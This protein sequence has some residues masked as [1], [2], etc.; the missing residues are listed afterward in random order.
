MAPF[1]SAFLPA[2]PPCG[3]PMTDSFSFIANLPTTETGYALKP[4]I[5]IRG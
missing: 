1:Y 5:E 4:R 3:F 2:N